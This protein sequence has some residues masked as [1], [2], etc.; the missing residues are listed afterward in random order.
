MR[1]DKRLDYLDC[2]EDPSL[3]NVKKIYES[4]HDVEILRR[5]QN[6]GKYWFFR[7]HEY[8]SFHGDDDITI[9]HSP[10]TDEE[11]KTILNSK[12]RPDLSFLR[13]RVSFMEDNEG[14]RKVKRQPDYPWS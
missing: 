2:C 3:I 11:A 5:C 9:W 1:D 12:E 8:V 14:V 10:L 7:F 4:T 6:C 13:N